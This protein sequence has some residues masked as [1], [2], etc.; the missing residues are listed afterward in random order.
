VVSTLVPTLV[1]ML[2]STDFSTARNQATSAC[3]RLSKASR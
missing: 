2:E 1:A 3:K